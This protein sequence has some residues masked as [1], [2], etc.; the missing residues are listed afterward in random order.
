MQE[1]RMS[2][3]A[4]VEAMLRVLSTGVVIE[5][6]TDRHCW[7]YAAG[8]RAARVLRHVFST[9]HSQTLL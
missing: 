9:L 4:P 7:A 8:H 6:A 1:T 3:I 5:S 2:N